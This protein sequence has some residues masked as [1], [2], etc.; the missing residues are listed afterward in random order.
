MQSARL[1]LLCRSTSKGGGVLS[2]VAATLSLLVGCGDESLS[3]YGAGD[4]LWVL[5][6]LDGNTFDARAEITFDSGGEVSGIAPCNLYH[7]RQVA[8]YP[9]IQIEALAVTRRAC[10]QLR[11]EARYLQALQEMAEA[12]VA[13]EVLIL[14]NQAG[15]EMLF[16]ATD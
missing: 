4:R 16:R 10:P 7:G 15:R 11:E 13:G 1:S 14:R 2:M 9:W 6:Q 3:A 5:Q 8:P 12:E